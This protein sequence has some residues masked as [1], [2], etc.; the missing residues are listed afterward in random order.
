MSPK[1]DEQAVE[2]VAKATVEQHAGGWRLVTAGSWQISV[3]PDGLLLLP[4]HLHPGEVEDFVSAV[5]TAAEVGTR[6]RAIN[7][8]QARSDNRSPA[9]RSARVQQRGTSP[10]AVPVPIMPR[11]KLPPG[12]PHAT[13]GR[14]KTSRTLGPQP[15]GNMGAQKRPGV[16]RPP[17]LPGQSQ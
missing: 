8:E 10:G 7:E 12:R 3:G 6:I 13:I 14:R 11:G 9:S 17:A 16:P 4:R 15:A 1:K 2:P 5:T